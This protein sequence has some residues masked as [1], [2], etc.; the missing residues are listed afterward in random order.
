MSVITIG[1]PSRSRQF[2]KDLVA[3]S[4]LAGDFPVHIKFTNRVVRKLVF[5]EIP[6][7]LL[8]PV[9]SDYSIAI[10]RID[11][12]ASLHRL[13]SSIESIAEVNRYLEMITLEKFVYPE[14]LKMQTHTLSG[15]ILILPMVGVIRPVTVTLKSADVTRKLEV[16][17]D[18]GEEYFALAIDEISATQLV[19]TIN[20]PITHLKAT[21]AI[22]DLLKLLS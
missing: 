21:G 6:G 8:G 17:T 16:S 3:G 2:A 4:F 12:L 10:I 13:A 1:A 18:G 19:S 15:T 20:G 14:D 9:D 5:P 7:L 22:N 11:S